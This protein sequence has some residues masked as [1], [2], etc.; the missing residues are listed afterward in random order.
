MTATRSGV[1]APSVSHLLIGT[2]ALHRVPLDR[3]FIR[4][5]HGYRM[6]AAHAVTVARGLAS[7][8]DPPP[9]LLEHAEHGTFHLRDGRHRF[10]AALLAGRPDI[11]AV[12]ADHIHEAEKS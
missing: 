9:V 4:A 3:I 10:V 7:G 2:A 8:L 12:V 6:D 5:D 1:H 11:L